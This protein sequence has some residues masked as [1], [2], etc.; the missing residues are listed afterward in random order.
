[1]RG[2]YETLNV[3]VS[4]P[5]NKE[6]WMYNLD[7]GLDPVS[8]AVEACKRGEYSKAL[9]FLAAQSAMVQ[10]HTPQKAPRQ[11]IT[12][13]RSHISDGSQAL[14]CFRYWVSIFT[15]PDITVTHTGEVWRG[16]KVALLSQRRTL[17]RGCCSALGEFS[18]RGVFGAVRWHMVEA[19][20]KFIP[21]VSLLLLHGVLFSI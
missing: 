14:Q 8:L 18:L 6:E 17:S 10:P 4:N 12:T 9:V 5:D 7:A 15:T 13:R 16:A 1:M 2:V 20:T 11:Q 19:A 3:R 21:S